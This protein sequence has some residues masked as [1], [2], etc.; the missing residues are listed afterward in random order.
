MRALFDPPTDP[1][2]YPFTHRL[3][4]RFADTDAMGLVHHAA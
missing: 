4:A 2:A 3:R 1:A